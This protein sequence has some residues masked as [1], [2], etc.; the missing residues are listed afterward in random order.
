MAVT[1]MTNQA[2][3][4]APPAPPP[5]W[6][7]HKQATGPLLTWPCGHH[8][9]EDVA[10]GMT[11]AVAAASYRQVMEGGAGQGEGGGAGQAW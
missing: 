4:V 3:A 9:P 7:D 5:P 10:P 1:D 8:S 6:P 11:E 2:G